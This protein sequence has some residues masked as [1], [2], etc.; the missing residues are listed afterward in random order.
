M[1]LHLIA[2]IP[3][4]LRCIIVDQLSGGLI[5]PVPAVRKA[6]P[7]CLAQPGTLRGLS[8]GLAMLHLVLF[9]IA[10]CALTAWLVAA[11]E[12]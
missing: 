9:G 6:S 5:Q 10:I 3:E 8:Q 12:R 4:R 1:R 2:Y 11:D 7:G